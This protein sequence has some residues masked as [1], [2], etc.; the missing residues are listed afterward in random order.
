MRLENGI[1]VPR[2]SGLPDGTDEGGG[3]PTYTKG[4]TDRS[5]VSRMSRTKLKEIPMTDARI[6]HTNAENVSFF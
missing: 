2:L 3:S 6:S 4:I 1:P 5:F